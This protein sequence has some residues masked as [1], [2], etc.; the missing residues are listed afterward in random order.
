MEGKSAEEKR[1][2]HVRRLLSYYL[3][4]SLKENEDGILPV[5]E[6]SGGLTAVEAVRQKLANTFG[7]EAAFNMEGEIKEILGRDIGDWLDGPFIKWH[8]KLYKRTPI[9]WQLSS[10]DYHNTFNCFL[11]Y[12]KI[13]SDTLRKVQTQYLWPQKRAVEN[14]LTMA[15]K[16]LQEGVS[17]AGSRVEDAEKKLGILEEFEDS[18]EMV[19][20]G[21]APYTP[22]KW[23]EGP[24]RNGIYD[25]VIDD[26]VKVNLMP[27]QK[28]R[29]L[30][31]KRLI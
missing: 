18:L 10:D 25:P 1:K 9:I 12:H 20:H 26:S 24:I 8:T 31:Y 19:I 14:N 22:P 23:A 11:Y 6:A 4:E 21:E 28:A 17:G 7:E 5:F 30:R 29:I 16:D 2:E 27:L 3:I 13:D 15:Q